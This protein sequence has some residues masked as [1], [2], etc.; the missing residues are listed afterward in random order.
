[1]DSGPNWVKIP[2]RSSSNLL[3]S[4]G[5]ETTNVLDGMEAW[6]ISENRR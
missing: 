6:T 1:M 5:P 3:T 2:G 4:V